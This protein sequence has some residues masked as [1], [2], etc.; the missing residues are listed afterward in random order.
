MAPRLLTV[1]RLVL[2]GL[3]RVGTTGDVRSV[4]GRSARSQKGASGPSVVCGR[5]WEDAV[6]KDVL[7][8]Q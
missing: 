3:Q 4:M 6:C 2:T 8:W 1:R 7:P 5:V